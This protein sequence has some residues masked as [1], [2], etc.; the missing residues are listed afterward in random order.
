MKYLGTITTADG[1]SKTNGSTSS[2]FSLP[3]RFYIQAQDVDAYY[4]EVSASATTTSS[5]TGAIA[6]QY[7]II[8]VDLTNLTT[9]GFLACKPT[10]GNTMT[11][12]VFDR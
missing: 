5:T 12:K 2:A 10:S 9:T 7:A 3:T 6:P 1:T 4:E 8:A 11:V